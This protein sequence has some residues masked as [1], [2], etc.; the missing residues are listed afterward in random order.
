MTSLYDDLGVSPDASADEIKRA[1]RKKASD[2]HPDR[3]GG[4]TE[5][6]QIVQ[7]AYSILGDE[8]KRK[9]YDQS[10]QTDEPP[11]TTL[12]A[13]QTLS[14]LFVNTMQQADDPAT[15]DLLGIVKHK[16][17]DGLKKGEDTLLKQR[18]ERNKLDKVITRLKRKKAGND[19]ILLAVKQTL[20]QLEAAME[21]SQ[22]GI[23]VGEEMLKL[24]EEYTYEFEE[25]A[26]QA[27]TQFKHSFDAWG[28][29]R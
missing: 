28:P 18:R 19:F 3:K 24:L 8:T 22:Q 26:P 17:R 7:V 25:P 11:S 1:F 5:K 12:L 6:F 10:G 9:R 15:S 2:T 13:M 21:Q 16:I 20:Q 27:Y 4:S 14:N 29:L 23:D